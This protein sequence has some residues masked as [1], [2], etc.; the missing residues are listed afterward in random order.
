MFVVGCVNYDKVKPMLLISA[1]FFFATKVTS[2]DVTYSVI[3]I[4]CNFV[5]QSL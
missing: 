2:K 3:Q 1:Q 4:P 5:M